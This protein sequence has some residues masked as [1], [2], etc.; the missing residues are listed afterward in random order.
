MAVPLR[1]RDIRAMAISVLA[2]WLR[3]AAEIEPRLLTALARDR[4][5]GV[6]A[7]ARQWRSR[8]RRVLTEDIRLDGL[9]ALE[10]EYRAL[11]YDL[12][13]GVDEAGVAPLAGPVVA[14]AVILPAGIRF[15]RLNDS[16]QLPA[17][18]RE[19]LFD[20]IHSR[21][22]AV[23]V[24][25]ATVEEIARLN[26]LQATRLAHRRAIEG[27]AVRPH[28]VLIDGRFP[29]DAPVVQM[30]VVDGDATCAAIAAASIIA[31]VTRDRLMLDL[32]QIYPD[33]G[34][35]RHKG[36]GT[37]THREAIRRLGITPIHRRSFLGIQ[38]EQ[39][40]LNR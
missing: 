4:R 25:L 30:P 5:R 27:L 39:I 15:R 1:P 19:R 40:L 10:R 32:A 14:A 3:S 22:E 38:G 13:A 36:Y 26:V 37:R 23:H 11:G 7:L 2:A 6:R 21:A 29:A 33:Y 16:K 24:G 8:R 17:D 12:I 34:F 31:K 9:G 20:E 28:L 35:A 18:E